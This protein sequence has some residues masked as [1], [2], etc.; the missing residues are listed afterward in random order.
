MNTSEPLPAAESAFM[1]NA[2]EIDILPG[3]R[4]DLDE[5]LAS[6][7]PEELLRVLLPLVDRG[8]I[9]VCRVIP[10][11]APDGRRGIQAGAPLAREELPK[12]LADA[13]NWEYPGGGDW[14]GCLTLTLT[15]QGRQIP[16]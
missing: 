8:W 5:P 1:L 6:A 14:I 3:V 15:H 4:G 7:A 12:V 13:A 9:E 10:L 11:A 2:F 16:W